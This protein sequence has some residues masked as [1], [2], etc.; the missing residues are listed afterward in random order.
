[1]HGENLCL[2][3]KKEFE[4]HF[5]SQILY[6][7]CHYSVYVTTLFIIMYSTQTPSQDISGTISKA[8]KIC[9]FPYMIQ[10][11]LVKRL[12]LGCY[13]SPIET[14]GDFSTVPRLVQNSGERRWRD[15]LAE[16]IVSY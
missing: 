1:M 4:C 13:P 11:W 9:G 5:V 14:V 10:L 2:L 12:P 6:P 8:L 7:L 3:N 15:F 16:R